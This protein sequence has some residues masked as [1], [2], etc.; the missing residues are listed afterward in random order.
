MHKEKKKLLQIGCKQIFFEKKQE[1]KE[2][3]EKKIAELLQQ[4]NNNWKFT[5]FF[6]GNY[7]Q[8]FKTFSLKLKL[9][10]TT[11]N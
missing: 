4:K 8:N 5:Y 11:N 2:L 3:K 1:T 9:N 10:I 6:F 7:K